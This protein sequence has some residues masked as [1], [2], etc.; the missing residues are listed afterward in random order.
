MRDRPLYRYSDDEMR[1]IR[2]RIRKRR[3]D[4]LAA[5]WDPILVDVHGITVAEAGERGM[6]IDV[7]AYGIRG[8]RTTRSVGGSSS[9]ADDDVARPRSEPRGA[10]R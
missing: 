9:K 7:S 10:S 5:V 3:D 8:T 1:T 2:D 6:E 4:W